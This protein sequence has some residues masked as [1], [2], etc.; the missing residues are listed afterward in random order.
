MSCSSGSDRLG[1]CYS[2]EDRGGI[3]TAIL[4]ANT[5]SCVYKVVDWVDESEEYRPERVASVTCFSITRSV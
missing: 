2:G 1:C 3:S 4:A 5:L